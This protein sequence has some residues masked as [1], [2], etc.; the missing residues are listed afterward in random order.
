MKSF[1]KG[2]SMKQPRLNNKRNTRIAALVAGASLAAGVLTTSLPAGAA[3][4]LGS[5]TA[6]GPEAGAVL[7]GG[8]VLWQGE[9]LATRGAP[10]GFSAFNIGGAAAASPLAPAGVV[11][12]PVSF[13]TLLA[14][15]DSTANQVR[16]ANAGGS[17]SA[18]TG[19]V[20]GYD[21]MMAVGNDLWL[22]KTGAVEKFTPNLT[23]NVLGIPTAVG[24]FSATSTMRMAVGP[25]GNVWIVEKSAGVDTLTRFS[26]AGVIVGA[27][28]NFPSNSADPSAIVLGQDQAMWVIQSGLNSIARFDATLTK[29]ELAL[30]AGSGV[31]SIAAGP[32]GVWI[33]ETA[34]NNASW[35]TFTGGAF[36]RNAYPAPSSFGLKDIA[37]GADGNMWAVGTI[38]NKIAK[39]GTVA[40]TTTTTAP[41]TT[42]IAVTTTGAPTTTAAPITT[43]APTTAVPTTLAPPTTIIKGDVY[44]C[45]KSARKRVKVG[46]KFVFKVVCTK[47]KRV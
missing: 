31:S 45:V 47:F 35:L 32:T 17:V 37:L 40:P 34:L 15:I 41:P 33:T 27:P 4:P 11:K 26:P 16:V 42:T 36:T 5:A 6:Y 29:A 23:T 20:T 13:G 3:D 8:I 7:N 2:N 1:P 28:T 44:R 9:M 46:K 18:L 19:S 22:S 30:P 43:V 25:D 39:F 12:S 38:A 24:T 14:W 10:G 21:S